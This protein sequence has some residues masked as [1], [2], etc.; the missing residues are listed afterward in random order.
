VSPKKGP[1]WDLDNLTFYAYAVKKVMCTGCGWEADADSDREAQV[2]SLAHWREAHR[3]AQSD[4][5]GA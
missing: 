1:A 2:L 5:P 4:G 3:P